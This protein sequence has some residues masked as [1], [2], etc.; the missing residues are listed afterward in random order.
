MYK[1]AARST[2]AVL[3]LSVVLALAGCSSEV[4]PATIASSQASF[5][6]AKQLAASG[7]YAAGMPL[8]E[9]AIA[10]TGLN[11][12]QYASALLVRAQCLAD[13][14]EFEKAEADL[15]ESQLGD[16]D[17]AFFQLSKG[18]VLSKQGKDAEAKKAFAMAKRLDSNIQIP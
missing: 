9:Q 3:L 7:N 2:S 18:I 17:P 5:E 4:A 14:G 10:G 13:A 8:I 16:P 15:A 11:A 12:D 1:L 6:E